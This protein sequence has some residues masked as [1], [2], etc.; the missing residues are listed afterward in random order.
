MVWKAELYCTLLLFAPMVL[1]DL[2]QPLWIWW[3]LGPLAALILISFCGIAG[4]AG[5]R[6]S[7]RPTSVI[8]SSTLWV[9]VLT[10]FASAFV[11]GQALEGVEDRLQPSDFERVA[12]FIIDRA[13]E[14]TAE[15]LL[16]ELPQMPADAP[17]PLEPPAPPAGSTARLEP[18][19]AGHIL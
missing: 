8:L 4:E 3:I 7:W 5:G 9:L 16:S 6:A 1:F 19:A 15:M 2:W 14:G 10:W 12:R 18:V 11:T 13:P 17:P